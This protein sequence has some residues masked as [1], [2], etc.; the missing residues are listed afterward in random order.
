MTTALTCKDKT[1]A[2]KG[3]RLAHKT[4][5]VLFRETRKIYAVTTETLVL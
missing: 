4:V 5:D 1:F 3:E 2:S